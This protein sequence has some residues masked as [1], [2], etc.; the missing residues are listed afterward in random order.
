MDKNNAIF[1]D[2]NSMTWIHRISIIRK[3][4][5]IEHN[6][7]SVVIPG[8]TFIPVYSVTFTSALNSLHA[9]L[10]RILERLNNDSHGS[11]HRCD[12]SS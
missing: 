1:Q 8:A 7:K 2:H 3:K 4:I 12:K 6:G 10:G 11:P 9:E 5:T